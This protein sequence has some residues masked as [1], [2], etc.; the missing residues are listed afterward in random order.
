MT[1]PLKAPRVT[2]D[3]ETRSELNLKD[4]GAWA[5]AQ[6]PSTC[7]LCLSYKPKGE[8]VRLWKPG[9]PIPADLLRYIEQDRTFE[10]HNAQFE[11]AIWIII[12]FRQFGVPV[13]K[14][15]CDSLATCAYKSIPLKLEKAGDVLELPIQKN[16]RGGYLLGR[17]SKPRKYLKADKAA[18]KALEIP[19]EDWPVIYNND[20]ELLEEL[21]SYCMQDSETEECLSETLGDLTNEE[22]RV[23]LLDQKINQRGVAVDVEATKAAVGI[24]E[25]LVNKMTQELRDVTDNKVQTAGQLDAITLWLSEHGWDMTNMQADTIKDNIKRVADLISEGHADLKPVLRVLQLRKELAYTSPKK[26]YKILECLCNDDRLRG[27]LQYHGAGTGRWSGR[28]FQPQN[29]PRGSLGDYCDMLDMGP[30]PCMELLISTIKLG[31]QAAL[32]ALEL[33]FGDPMDALITALRGMLCAAPG[34]VFR[35]ADFSAIEAV[36]NA[37][38]AGEDWKVKAFEEI[39]QGKGYKGSDDIYCATASKIFQRTIT[40]KHDK[41][42][43]GVGKVCELAFGYQGGVGAWRNFDDSDTYS[44]LEVD[45][46]KKEWRANH[47]A[48]RN[49]WFGFEKAAI[50][51]VNTGKRQQYGMVFFDT[52]TDDAGK[53]FTITLPNSRKLWY[54]NPAVVEVTKFGELQ[55][56]LQYEGRDNKRG[57]AWGIVHAYGGL[58]CE[59]IVQAIARDLM[60]ESMFLV[61]AHG[62]CIVLTVHDEIVS[63]DD[64]D[65]GSQTEFENLMSTIPSWASGC[66]VGVD[67]WAGI[68]YRK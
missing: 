60:V 51:A 29:L 38:L 30:G 21:Y 23:W 24:Y 37:W 49:Q 15:W 35:V 34:K 59:N 44:D 17:L 36:V 46:F 43:R 68:R 50:K 62:Y 13:P 67:G 66:P 19:E 55:D 63:E 54:Y 20:P 4:V 14:K 42:E 1:H 7:I 39:N 47:P 16:K 2:V 22:Y 41:K 33:T 57:G 52:E 32:D 65:F 53:W 25:L 40:K 48:I 6:H 18:M 3:F 64:E 11:R 9:Q 12:L 27:L 56:E 8:P 58:I 31:G 26:Y 61:D 5:Y 10:A 28:L 45:N